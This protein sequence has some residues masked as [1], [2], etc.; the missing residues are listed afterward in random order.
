MML[1]HIPKAVLRLVALCAVSGHEACVR[2]LCAEKLPC[3]ASSGAL[4][5][6]CCACSA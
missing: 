3:H 5:S 2:A 4:W 6:A 1:F